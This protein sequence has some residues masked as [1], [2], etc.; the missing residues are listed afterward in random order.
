[1]RWILTVVLALGIV[2]ARASDFIY[3]VNLANPMHASPAERA[4]LVDQL[5]KAGVKV[6][7]ASLTDASGNINDQAMVFAKSLAAQGI[8]LDLMLWPKFKHD[9]PRRPY[10]PVRYPGMW[11]GAPLSAAD[12]DLSEVFFQDVFNKFDA[13][14]I[15]LVSVELGN[16]VNGADFNPD[17]PLAAS[18]RVFDLHDLASVP[19]AEQVAR[20]YLQ[21]LKVM[22]RLKKVRDHASLNRGAALI[23][24]GLTNTGPTGQ[25]VTGRDGVSIAATIAFWRENGLDQLVDGY[26][27]HIY[28]DGRAPNDPVATQARLADMEQN[29]I[30][31][32]SVSENGRPC[33]ITEWG[34]K[35]IDD[36]CPPKEGRRTAL[37]QQFRNMISDLSSQYRIK[38]AMY[39]VWNSDPWAKSIDPYSVYRCGALTNPGRVAIEP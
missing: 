24:A 8:E 36:S 4:E 26:G 25:S 37:V 22:Q 12:A 11:G 21:Y 29:A 3:G 6:V 39:F 18:G 16:E 9:A 2:Q 31:V 17:F 35:N 30:S 14:G 13:A 19:E 27:V 23:S 34:F 32:C 15:K 10:S 38:S 7:R 20:G 5:A 28:P 1:M 33:W